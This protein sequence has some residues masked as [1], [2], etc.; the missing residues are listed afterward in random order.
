LSGWT[1]VL[2]DAKLGEG[3]RI[4]PDT[5]ALII[6]LIAGVAGG[7]ATGELLKGNY[8]LGPGNTVTGAIGGVIGAL[9]LQTLIPA[10]AGFDLRAI[11]SQVIVAAAGGAGLTVMVATVRTRRRRRH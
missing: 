3:D 10:L 5:V 7:N 9:I 11:L 1:A 6:W 4:V 8:D 2:S